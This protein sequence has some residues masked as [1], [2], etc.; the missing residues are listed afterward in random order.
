MKLFQ[1]QKSGILFLCNKR[2]AILGD[3]MGTG[4][5]LQA[6]VGIKIL[7]EKS[8]IKQ[9]LIVVP[10]NQ[11]I[12]NNW[13]TEA[14]RISL[15][16]SLYHGLKRE[17]QVLKESVIL[18][19]YNTLCRDIEKFKGISDELCLVLDEAHYIKD[20]STQR[21]KQV[22]RF[23]SKYRWALTGTPICNRPEDLYS[24][25]D[26]V[27]SE[28]AGSKPGWFARF[29]ELRTF[30]IFTRSG[31][32][33]L[34]QKPV[35]VKNIPELNELLNSIML[36]RTKEDC[37][38]DGVFSL[39][40]KHIIYQPYVL[41]KKTNGLVELISDELEEMGEPPAKR[42]IRW[43]QVLDGIVKFSDDEGQVKAIEY[44]E[45]AKATVLRELIDQRSG[46]VIVWFKYREALQWLK[47]LWKELE[48]YEYSGENQT[49]RSMELQRWQKSDTGILFA[50]IKSAGVGLNL[51]QCDTSIFYSYEF[52]PSENMQAEDRIYRIGQER[53]CTIYYL[54]GE[55]TFER[56][57]LDLLKKKRQVTKAVVDSK[58]TQE[59]L[60]KL[61]SYQLQLW[62][63][64]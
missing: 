19:S 63:R 8:R 37:I 30:Q 28:L 23:Q 57:V 14:Q 50:T 38:R 2:N 22:K 47:K 44:F 49:T 40:K 20:A 45:S 25:I 7:L 55:G 35:G 34:K 33:I 41:D 59:D 10:G 36:R 29:V 53:P 48:V 46:K 56:L 42:L 17:V 5:T 58:F 51:T 4:K 21:A 13:K 39:P 64:R 32:P 15:P 26:F 16:V 43:Q 3:A 9:A 52:S 24:L 61:Y 12:L 31:F 60:N 18:T 6:L 1:H 54:Y 62:D 11:D 27:D